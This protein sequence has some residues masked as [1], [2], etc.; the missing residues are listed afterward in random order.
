MSGHE[1]ETTG[2]VTPGRVEAALSR[3]GYAVK[4]VSPTSVTGGWDGNTFTVSLVGDESTYLQIRGTW[5]GTVEHRFAAELAQ[6]V[7]DW[8]RDRI[9]PKVFTE[10]GDDGLSA[11]AEVSLDL[12]AGVTD[13][14][15]AEAIACG[16]GT[17]VQFFDALADHVGPEGP[18]R[19]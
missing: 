18:V 14:Q 5:H 1:P 10:R 3:Q 4:R 7:N 6:T 15:L 8:N 12:S 9:W 11:H 13:T 17:G 19:P 16:L 2:P